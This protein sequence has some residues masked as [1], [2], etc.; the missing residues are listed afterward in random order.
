MP[1]IDI[2]LPEGLI[3]SAEQGELAQLLGLALLRA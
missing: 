1:V 2:D 3:P